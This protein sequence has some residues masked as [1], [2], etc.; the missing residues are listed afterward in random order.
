MTDT[1]VQV[2]QKYYA[3]KLTVPVTEHGCSTVANR[4][5][6]MLSAFRLLDLAGHRCI[7]SQLQFPPQSFASFMQMTAELKFWII[8]Q[9]F[10]VLVKLSRPPWSRQLHDR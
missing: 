10:C 5:D 3:E 4:G 6:R 2:K 1:M 9:V 7:L 8:V